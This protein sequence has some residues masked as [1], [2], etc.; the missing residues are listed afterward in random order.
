[1]ALFNGYL[2]DKWSAPEATETEWMTFAK[3]QAA[4]DEMRAKEAADP[5][6]LDVIAA[7]VKQWVSRAL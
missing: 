5:R 3:A 2:R 4:I 1:M 6:E 7:F